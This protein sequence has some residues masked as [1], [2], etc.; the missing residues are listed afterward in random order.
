M[1]RLLLCVVGVFLASQLFAEE[2]FRRTFTPEERAQLQ[3]E[4]GIRPSQ[5]QV[6]K[7]LLFFELPDGTLPGPHELEAVYSVRGARHFVEHLAFDVEKAAT[8]QVIDLLVWHP[9]KRAEILALA[10]NRD[11]RV[12][13]SIKLDGVRVQTLPLERLRNR[14]EVLTGFGFTPLVTRLVQDD[15]GGDGIARLFT[16]K[17]QE[18]CRAGCYDQYYACQETCDYGCYVDRIC[19]R[20]FDECYY[21]GCPPDCHPTTRTYSTRTVLQQYPVDAACMQDYQNP[22]A[23]G[24]VYYLFY[25]YERFENH[26]ETRYCDGTTSDVVTSVSYHQSYCMS[27]T[28]SYCSPY[29]NFNPSHPFCY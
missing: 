14:T 24:K 2:P 12:Q 19:E 25:T 7:D 3:K 6:A 22:F 11:N 10:K 1:K 5:E 17:N 27:M 29:G 23:G 8:G 13:V 9:E 15:R 28:G 18:E 21:Y 4:L 26:Q 20:Q 16:P